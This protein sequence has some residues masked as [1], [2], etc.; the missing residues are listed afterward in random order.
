[1]QLEE[2]F[3]LFFRQQLQAWAQTIDR[4][5]PWKGSKNAYFIWL[6]EILL[7]QTR[8]EQGLPYYEKFVQ[9]FPTVSDLAAAD[10]DTVLKLWQGL[11]YYARA[12]NLHFTAKEIVQQHGGIF[13][14]T[15]EKI[16]KL[17]GI[18]DYTA[19]AIASFGFDL[20]Y[21]VVD[22]NVY[23]VLARLLDEA[24][25]IDTP[26]GKK[27]FSEWAQTL[28]DPLAPAAHNQA[29]M[30]FGA[31]HCRP[32]KPLCTTCPL[33]SR[34]RAFAQKTVAE[35]P[36]K[37]KKIAKKNRFLYYFIFEWQG[38]TFLRRRSKGDIWEGLYDFP[39]LEMD[40]YTDTP[41]TL[42]AAAQAE[43]NFPTAFKISSLS[44]PFRQTLTHQQLTAVFVR[45]IL[46]QSPDTEL[47]KNYISVPFDQI[48]NFASPRII[49]DYWTQQQKNPN[50]F[51]TFV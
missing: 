17:K 47:F 8:A 33:A 42:L 12:R 49:S 26:A 16:R 25:P 51:D 38:K 24:T 48:Q 28:L 13:P 10:E 20:P 44:Q 39:S 45:T 19:A 9:A 15:Y 50:L 3:I 31:I 41:E 1:M 21:A 22:G 11:G 30:D 40:F 14:Q 32:Q 18:G 46:T 23:R 29:I 5:L 37:S 43:P 34:C 35:L 6:S 7:Q 2:N 27:L 4:P 36:K